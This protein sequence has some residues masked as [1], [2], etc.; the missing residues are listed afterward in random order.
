MVAGPLKFRLNETFHQC[1]CSCA[2]AHTFPQWFVTCACSIVGSNNT[3]LDNMERHFMIKPLWLWS[4]SPSRGLQHHQSQHFQEIQ[5]PFTTLRVI[6]ITDKQTWPPPTLVEAIIENSDRTFAESTFLD[7][8]RHYIF[9]LS[10]RTIL[11]EKLRTE[12]S[13]MSSEL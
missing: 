8:S 5:N 2:A 1:T 3:A 11:W 12:E 10:L 7:G 13:C 4:F 9:C 6:L